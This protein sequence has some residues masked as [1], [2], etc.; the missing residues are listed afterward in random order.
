MPNAAL[1]FGEGTKGSEADMGRKLDYEKEV[2]GQMLAL[3]CRRRHGADTLCP[4]CRELKAYA[5][6]RLDRCPFGD[7]KPACSSCKIHC[8]KADMRARI[9]EVMRFAAPRMLLY[10]PFAFVK[11][12]VRG[13]FEK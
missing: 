11:H 2:I 1:F 3:Y 6:M 4:A 13:R 12:Y 7:A 10:H 9:R 8:Y 5:D